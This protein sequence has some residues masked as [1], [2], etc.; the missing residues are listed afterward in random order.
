MPT[1]P[2]IE[3]REW[4]A[5]ESYGCHHGYCSWHGDYHDRETIVRECLPTEIAWIE[6]G[7][8]CW[9]GDFQRRCLHPE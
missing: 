7:P 8:K 9:C 1:I 2:D 5:C 6:S 4:C 3:V